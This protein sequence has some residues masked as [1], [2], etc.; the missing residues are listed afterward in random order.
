MAAQ[1]KSQK[2]NLKRV[3]FHLLAKA[4]KVYLV[5]DF[6]KW[7]RSATP[8]NK[9]KDRKW[10]RRLELKPGRYEYRF[11]V[12]GWWWNDPANKELAPNPFG[13][14]NNVLVV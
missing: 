10:V 5:G 3:T 7:D 8:M 11:L 6:N 12:D 4:G 2:A 9:G 13:S 14:F 1:K